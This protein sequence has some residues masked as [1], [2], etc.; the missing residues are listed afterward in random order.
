[1]TV[2]RVAPALRSD[3]GGIVSTEGAEA[4]AAAC[5]AARF[6][7]ASLG[8]AAAGSGNPVVPLVRDLAAEVGDAAGAVHVGATSQDILD[9]AWMLVTQRAAG[10]L[11]GDLQAAADAAADL[12]EQH[13]D[14]LVTGRTLLQQALPTTFGLKAAGWVAGLDAACDRLRAVA[15]TRLAAQLWLREAFARLEIDADAMHATL[16]G[17]GDTLLAEAVSEA[18]RPSLGRQRAH[19]LVRAVQAHRSR[20]P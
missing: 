19:D 1:M 17:A 16:Q 3:G 7:P 14:T 4:V 11:L 9:T 20:Q 6:D 13:R 18:L 8:Q 12:A 15:E 10:A 2:E 5:D